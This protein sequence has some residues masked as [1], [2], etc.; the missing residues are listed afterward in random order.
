MKIY[1][2]TR[3]IVDGDY[4]INNPLRK[5]GENQ[6]WLAKEIQNALP[7][8]PFRLFCNEGTGYIEFTTDLTTEEMQTIDTVVYNHKNNL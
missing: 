8:K 7:D 2:F 4:N 1:N 5:D 3:E 6:R